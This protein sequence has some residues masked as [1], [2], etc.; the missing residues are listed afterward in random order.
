MPDISGFTDFVSSTEI[1]HAQN[2]IQEVLEILVES[3]QLDLE[4]GEIEGDA[5]FFYRIG[6]PPGLEQL[7]GQVQ[8]MFTRFHQHLWQYDHQRIC[9]CGACESAVN[10]KLKIIAHF[11][12]VAGISVKQHR[13][14]FGKEVIVIH[15]LLKNSLDKKEYALFTQ[16]L[17]EKAAPPEQLPQWYQPEDATEKYDVGDIYFK[18]ADLTRLKEELPPV[19]K[20]EYQLSD[21]TKVVFT[22]EELIPASMGEVFGAIFDLSLRPKWME[23]VKAI[24]MLSKDLINRVGTLHKCVVGDR[25]DPVILTEYA[26]IGTDEIV[27]VEMDQKGMGGCRYVVQKAGEEATRL[28]VDLLLKKDFITSVFFNLFM[29]NKMIIRIVKSMENL[30]AFLKPSLS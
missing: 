4:V 10:L 26:H 23:G 8:T 12:D 7:L 6:S 15:R 27:L 14:L 18:V 11:G 19:A 29:K 17:I 20:Q 1:L 22:G 28:K 2:I 30:K 25:N 16:P 3:N 21:K 9:P 5:V 24:E 13:K